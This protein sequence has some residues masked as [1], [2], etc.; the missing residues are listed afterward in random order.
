MGDDRAFEDYGKPLETVAT[1]KYMGRV[2]TAGD[3]DWPEVAENLVKARKSWG[4]L[5]QILSR[6]GADKR[7]SVNLFKSVVQAVL[8][9]GA[10]TWVL[11]PR[12][13]RALES[14]MHGAA[15]RITGKQPQRGGGGKWTYPP[16]K[17]AMLEAGFEGIRKAVTRRQNMVAQ[18]I[19]TR[20]ILDFCERATQRVEAR[21]SRRWWD[22]EGMDLKA[23]KEQAS[24]ALATDLES[25]SEVESEEEVET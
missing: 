13:E 5:S 6:E 23:A 3:D 2:M 20:P 16:L 1:L 4:R 15:R 9:F 7:V 21:V 24:E 14:F 17:E 18:Y 19:A 12:I 10:E 22:Q 25:E 11:N 8:L